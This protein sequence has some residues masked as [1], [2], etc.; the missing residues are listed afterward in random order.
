MSES[1]G[2]ADHAPRRN[3]N[4]QRIRQRPLIVHTLWITNRPQRYVDNR[5]WMTARAR[6]TATRDVVSDA[7]RPCEQA[8]DR[9]G[10]VIESR[11]L[12]VDNTTSAGWMFVTG[13]PGAASSDH[14]AYVAG[15]YRDGA[16]SDT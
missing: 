13:R 2:D 6:S 7:A 3:A 8:V 9:H 12:T 5:L 16:L 10:L 15:R 4:A 11:G 1:R 14:S